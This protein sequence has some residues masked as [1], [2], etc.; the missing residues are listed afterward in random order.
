MR[1]SQGQI[2]QFP[3]EIGPCL[4]ETTYEP[5]PRVRVRVRVRVRL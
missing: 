2:L 3:V 1:L 5:A 4:E